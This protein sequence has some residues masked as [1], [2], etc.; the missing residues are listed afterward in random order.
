[1]A[2][3]DSLRLVGAGLRH[4]LD[5][6]PHAQQVAAPELRDLRVREAAAAQ[7]RR[8]VARLARIVPA[9][10]PAAAVEVRSESDVI[11]ARHVHGVLDVIQIVIERRQ[12][13]LTSS[14]FSPSW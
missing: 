1:M 10:D 11:D 8:D 12:R 3:K 6:A 14:R 7:A 4:A 13:E 2:S 9:L 5:V